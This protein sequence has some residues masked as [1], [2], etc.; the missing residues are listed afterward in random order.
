MGE[1]AQMRP[2]QLAILIIN[3]VFKYPVAEIMRFRL[4]FGKIHIL[5]IV[6]CIIQGVV[7][8]WRDLLFPHFAQFQPKWVTLDNFG[9][10]DGLELLF[11]FVFFTL[12]HFIQIQI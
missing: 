2:F 7:F 3:P 9:L 6:I 12:F 1:L 8:P 10:F 5:F 4:Y 11:Y